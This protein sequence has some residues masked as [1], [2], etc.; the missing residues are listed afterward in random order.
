MIRKLSDRS[1]WNVQTRKTHEH[2]ELSR[3]KCMG[4]KVFFVVA[5]MACNPIDPCPCATVHQHVHLDVAAL[6]GFWSSSQ[7]QKWVCGW[8]KPFFSLTCTPVHRHKNFRVHQGGQSRG[9]LV[10]AMGEEFRNK[11]PDY[12]WT[13]SLH[14]FCPEEF[15]QQRLTVKGKEPVEL[16]IL[17]V[18]CNPSLWK[19]HCTHKDSEQ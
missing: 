17:K 18:I 4:Q 8:G 13:C 10:F 6:W 11:C 16:A 19:P 5:H 1:L 3:H 12:L 7:N 2:I 15:F 14:K 9:Y